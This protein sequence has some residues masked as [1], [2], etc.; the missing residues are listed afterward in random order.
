M[1]DDAHI[2]KGGAVPTLA[3][4]LPEE[5]LSELDRHAEKGDKNVSDFIHEEMELRHLHCLPERERSY[6]SNRPEIKRAIRQQDDMRYR[7]E[8]SGY[9]GS[10]VVRE[11]R[12]RGW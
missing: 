12:D 8:G 3:P 4:E 2:V 11:M 1:Y 5:L 10:A 7:L 6:I 9:S